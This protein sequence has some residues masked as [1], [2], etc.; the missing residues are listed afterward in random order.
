[1]NFTLKIWI[2]RSADCGNPEWTA[3][4]ED[5]AF[6]REIGRAVRHV[7]AANM[8]AEVLTRF[9]PSV[10]PEGIGSFRRPYH[11]NPN[12]AIRKRDPEATF[13]KKRRRSAGLKL[14]AKNK[15]C[16]KLWL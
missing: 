3:C 5:E 2:S 13:A 8:E 4:W 1:M 16:S 9:E 6:N 10:T 11:V 14:F 12:F 15:T 7:H